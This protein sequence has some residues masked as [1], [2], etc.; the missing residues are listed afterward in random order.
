[1]VTLIRGINLLSQVNDRVEGCG[2]VFMH[3]FAFLSLVTRLICVL[4]SIRAKNNMVE[5]GGECWIENYFYRA[6]HRIAEY[7]KS[8]FRRDIVSF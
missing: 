5:L 8:V 3:V 7:I 1:M 4:I 6:S 2:I